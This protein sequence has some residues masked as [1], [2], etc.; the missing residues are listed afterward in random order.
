MTQGVGVRRIFLYFLPDVVQGP[1]AVLLYAQSVGAL[2]RQ[3][4]PG[5]TQAIF[6]RLFPPIEGLRILVVL[7][8]DAGQIILRYAVALLGRLKVLLRELLQLHV[9]LHSLFL[10]F[11]VHTVH[12]LFSCITQRYSLSAYYSIFPTGK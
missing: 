10:F 11:L 1:V 9:P 6:R 7:I 3:A 12:F 2:E 5:L 4:D 8:I